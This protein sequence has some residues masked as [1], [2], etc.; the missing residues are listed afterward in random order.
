MAISR[1]IVNRKPQVVLFRDRPGDTVAVD[2]IRA[3]L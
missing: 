3:I 1:I 2:R